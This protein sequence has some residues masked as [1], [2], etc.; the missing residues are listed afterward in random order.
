MTIGIGVIGM[1]WMGSVHS[2]AYRAV[3][4]RFSAS[5]LAPRLCVCADESAE[6]AAAGA[7]RFEF[8]RHT[9]DWREVVEAADVQVVIVTTPNHLHLEIVQAAAAAGKHVMC[10]KPVG[11]SPQ[12]TAAACA[13]VKAAGV[14]ANWPGRG[15]WAT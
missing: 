9:T 12:E 14:N 3:P 4:D 13:A 10:E 11:R 5:G 1:G 6:R 8:E 2:R 15:L 7:R